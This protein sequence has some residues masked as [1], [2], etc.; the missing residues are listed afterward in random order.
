M[1][2]FLLLSRFKRV[3]I[4]GL[5]ALSCIALAVGVFGG[6]ASAQTCQPKTQNPSVTVCTPTVNSI[7]AI[8]PVH[9]TAES[10]DTYAVTTMQVYVDNS[11]VYQVNASTVN[12]YI[13]LSTGNHLVTVQGWDTTVRTQ[14]DEPDHHHLHTRQFGY[15]QPA[16]ASGGWN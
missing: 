12:T 1:I 15:R 8:S 3:H 14:F 10:T 4:P 16:H 7:A 5:S 13:P 9:V 2:H 11:L 6:Y